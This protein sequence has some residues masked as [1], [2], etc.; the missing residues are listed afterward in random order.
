MKTIALIP[1]RGGSKGIPGKNIK[2][3][4]GLPLIYYS[5][6]ACI[7]SKVDEVF[8]ATDSEEIKKEV[9]LFKITHPG[10]NLFI[11]N[12]KPENAQDESSTESLMLEFVEFK[13]GFYEDLNNFLLV[14]CTNPFLTARHIDEALKMF[15]SKKY[16]SILSC[17][18]LNRFIWNQDKEGGVHSVNYLYYVRSRRQDFNSGTYIENGAF[19]INSFKNIKFYENRLSENI[20]IYEM[21]EYT[22]IELDSREDWIIA[23]RIYQLYVEKK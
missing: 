5:L 10:A 11:Y 19:Y 13:K 14:Q 20:G 2:S 8:V 7:H 3:F 15:D 23:E 9:E 16:D 4:C 17:C 18:K 1:A 12:R 22:S 6:C 21:P